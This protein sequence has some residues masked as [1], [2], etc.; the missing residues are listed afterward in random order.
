MAYVSPTYKYLSAFLAGPRA[1]H[2]FL[3]LHPPQSPSLLL[4]PQPQLPACLLT[5]RPSLQKWRC[6]HMC[7]LFGP[8]ACLL[9]HN[10]CFFQ[11]TPSPV[12]NVHHPP[13]RG[14][15]SS[16]WPSLSDKMLRTADSWVWA[17]CWEKGGGSPLYPQ[18]PTVTIHVTFVFPY[19]LQA[20][21]GG[22][23]RRCLPR[24]IFPQQLCFLPIGYVRLCVF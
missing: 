5:P 11:P 4:C 14:P 19:Q 9:S 7:P 3:F 6:D 17:F 21:V 22:Q 18:R 20:Q 10:P 15:F 2:F 12:L 13:C 16:P 8:R 23:K 24:C 1:P